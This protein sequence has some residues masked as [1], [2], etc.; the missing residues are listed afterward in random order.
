M[1][2]DKIN[3]RARGPKQQLTRQTL[4]GRA[5]DGGLRIGEMERDGII[6]HGAS[7]FLNESFMVRGD[8]Y[9]MV[10]C[11]Q[12]GTIAVYNTEKK[13]M[14][15]LHSDGPLEFTEV[16]NSD[17][18]MVVKTISHYGRSFSI[19]RIPYTMKLL[20][21]EL[22]AMNIQMRLITEDTINQFDPITFSNN[23]GKLIKEENVNISATKASHYMK[24]II[25]LG[26][27]TPSIDT[28][29][30]NDTN[31]TNNN[32]DNDT[33]DNNNNTIHW[34]PNNEL[35]EF[36]PHTPPIYS[37]HIHTPHSP[38][39]PSNTPPHN[40]DNSNEITINTV[41]WGPNNSNSLNLQENKPTVVFQNDDGSIGK[42]K[43]QKKE[44][45]INE[46]NSNA[47]L[48]QKPED[49]EKKKNNDDDT[50]ASS[51]DTKKIITT[52]P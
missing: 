15:S 29:N 11:N 2:K 51:N 19:V 12:S 47:N 52:E 31:D 27:Q 5:N 6:A 49:E 22:Q 39:T 25:D 20:I 8:E 1:V 41:P 7:C 26:A 23:I 24:S 16:A 43:L 50:E 45:V 9:Y 17:E 42:A 36:E 35:N 3:Y 38:H 14:Y 37:P 21:Q 18:K 13:A 33:N 34:D 28:N 48:L 44:D 46:L 4:Q 32:N 30:N 40:T 10:V